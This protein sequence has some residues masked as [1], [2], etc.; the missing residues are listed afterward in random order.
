MG[1]LSAPFRHE[2]RFLMRREGESRLLCNRPSGQ[3]LT[4]RGNLN[5]T[6]ACREKRV[7]SEN[8]YDGPARSPV[9]QGETEYVEPKFRVVYPGPVA[10]HLMRQHHN[11][12]AIARTNQHPSG[13]LAKALSGEQRITNPR[14]EQKG[15]VKAHYTSRLM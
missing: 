11:G 15:T 2:L 12:Q 4:R 14:K 9:R 1:N 5:G 10:A 7:E 8:G 3:R 6:R 13:V